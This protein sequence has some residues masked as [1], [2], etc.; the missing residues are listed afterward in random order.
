[1]KKKEP[2]TA[3]RLVVA[4]EQLRRD[5]PELPALGPQD[6]QAELSLREALA[7]VESIVQTLREPLLVLDADLRVVSANPAFYRT[8]Q[9]APE[10]TEQRFLYEL[11]NRQW[12]IPE[13]RNLLEKIIPQEIIFEDFEVEHDFPH[14]GRRA[15]LLNARLISAKGRQPQR[16]LLAMEDITE[17]KR[18]REALQRAY[19]D[20]EK[21]VAERTQELAQANQQLQKEIEERKRAE[22]LLALKAEEL[23]RSNAELEQF[24][25]LV[26]HDLQEPLHVA[27]GFLRLLS[28][29][30]KK[31]L[32]AKG[33]EFIDCALDS[34]TRLEQQIKDLLDFS[35]LTTRAREFQV[36]ES[37]EVLEQVL[38]DMSLIIQE[39]KAQITWAPLPRILGDPS[40]VARLFQNLIGNALKFCGDKPPRIQIGAR[41][42]D[43]QWQF[44]VQDQG[45]GID[46]K[47]CDR[48]FLMFERLH[49]RSAYPGTGIGLAIC[50]KIVERH[51]GRIWVESAPGQ[52]ATF[53][54]TLPALPDPEGHNLPPAS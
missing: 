51:G 40:Q 49:S 24:A 14:I 10:E 37:N 27:A 38:K 18:A 50:K 7:F 19:E 2:D 25:Y 41:R 33:A 48:I 28:R 36:I 8:F 43:G 46:P 15:M 29:R 35:R 1:M 26:S 23:A 12:D 30:Y 11:G 20:L 3:D 5:H 16:I 22:R 45:I 53:Y 32:D 21:R 52:G 4:M 54:F 47:D 39:K 34:I 31:H 17:R 13:L 9:V 6:C 42:A 44:W